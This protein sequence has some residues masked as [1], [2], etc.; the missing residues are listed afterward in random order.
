MLLYFFPFLTVCEQ[1]CFATRNNLLKNDYPF[2][3]ITYDHLELKA[4]EFMFTV[5]E[6]KHIMKNI[7]TLF[8]VNMIC[9]E[10][11]DTIEAYICAPF[12]VD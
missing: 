6:L 11:K 9:I 7:Q 12:L 5:F 3:L 4:H 1:R 2:F 8:N 10:S